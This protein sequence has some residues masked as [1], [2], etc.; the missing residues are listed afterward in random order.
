MLIHKILGH[1]GW[2]MLMG[3]IAGLILGFLSL[4]FA[5]WIAF[6][7]LILVTLFLTFMKEPGEEN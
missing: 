7:L 2:I 5:G 3:T 4:N 6:V 1:I